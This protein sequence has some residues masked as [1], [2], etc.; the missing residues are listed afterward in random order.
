MRVTPPIFLKCLDLMGKRVIPTVVL[1][2]MALCSM[3]NLTKLKRKVNFYPEAICLLAFAIS[4][5][6]SSLNSM[7]LEHSIENEELI[8]KLKL[9]WSDFCAEFIEYLCFAQK[10]PF[11]VSVAIRVVSFIVPLMNS[12]NKTNI[13]VLW[14]GIAGTQRVLESVTDLSRV[15]NLTNLRRACITSSLPIPLVKAYFMLTDVSS[16]WAE[17]QK[18]YLVWIHMF[19]LNLSYEVGSAVTSMR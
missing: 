17:H 11:S 16:Q 19:S 8:E 3:E 15:A 5:V 1:M 9:H 2:N 14:G 12:S 4:N 10:I 7:A 13:A 18:N 6:E